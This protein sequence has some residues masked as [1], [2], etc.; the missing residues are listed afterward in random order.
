MCITART[1]L[2]CVPESAAAAR[3]WVVAQLAGMYADLQV[4]VDD[5]ALVV[6]ELATNCVRADGHRFVLGVEGHHARVSVATTDSAPGLPERRDAD[7][8]AATGRGLAIVEGLATRWGVAPGEH[9]KTVWADL[10]APPDSG[11]LFACTGAPRVPDHE[12]S[13]E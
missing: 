9:E 4:A 6:S 1:E 3:A 10:P 12:G 8:L 5:V 13:R 2:D 11:P 7:P